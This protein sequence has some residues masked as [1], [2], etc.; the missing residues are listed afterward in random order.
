M[1]ARLAVMLAALA[2]L[3]IGAAWGNLGAPQIANP[4]GGPDAGVPI[5]LPQEGPHWI[6]AATQPVATLQPFVEEYW[7]NTEGPRTHDIV[8]PVSPS[9]QWDRIVLVYRQ[10]PS[11]DPAQMDPWDR[12]CSASVAGVEVLRCTTPRS[13]MTLTKDLTEYRALFPQGATV[14]ITADTGSYDQ[15][16]FGY[17]GGQYVDVTLQFYANEPT[18]LAQLP[19]AASVVPMM[20]HQIVCAVGDAH[21]ATIDFPASPPTL[22]MVEITLSGHGDDEFWWMNQNFGSDGV[23]Y[24]LPVFKVYVDGTE[25]AQAYAMPYTYAFAGFYGGDNLEHPLMYWTAQQVLNDAGVYPGIG[26][27]PPYRA[28]LLPSALPLLTGPGHDVVLEGTGGLCYWPA[29]VSFL[30]R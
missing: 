11:T 20:D 6:P 2:L 7:H 15:P 26:Q 18:G 10:H 23:T 13:D 1:H 4:H 8:V 9:G 17:A 25:I 21:H 3:P 28:V 30:L 22:A 19:A 12:L 29:S 24:E 16:E 27:I 14:P 5:A